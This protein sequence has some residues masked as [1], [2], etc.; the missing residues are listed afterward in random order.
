ML[1]YDVGNKIKKIAVFF[2]WLG[3]ICS[4]I[5]GL[6]AGA[7]VGYRDEFNVLSFLL[8]A[9]AGSFSSVVSALVF[10]GFGEAFENIAKIRFQTE[11]L[12]DKL[13]EKDGGTK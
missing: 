8:V 6:A 11:L 12:Y 13:K 5:L 10:Y 4:I 2:M 7:P 1:F 9:V 3:V